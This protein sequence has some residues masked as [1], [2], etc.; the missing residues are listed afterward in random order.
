M[1]DRAVFRHLATRLVCGALLIAA[2][3]SRLRP[4][5]PADSLGIREGRVGR[6]VMGV[7]IDS[8]YRT[9]GKQRT[10]LIDRFREGQFDPAMEIRLGSPAAE[11]TMVVE[12]A[13][14]TC[15]PVVGRIEVFDPRFRTASGLHVG[16]TL[17]DVRRQHRVRISH[18]E[19]LRAWSP[20]LPMTFELDG[21]RPA[22][23][24]RAIAVFTVTTRVTCIDD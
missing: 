11:P 23:K 20:Q 12:V 16:S 3:P 19:G 10:R 7:S 2:A 4:Q 6:V 14:S 5:P 1:S 13:T 24:V 22:S 21:D 17:A 15:G 8:L 18:E 9:V